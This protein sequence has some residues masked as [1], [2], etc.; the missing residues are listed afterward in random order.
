MYIYIYIHK[1]YN[2]INYIT[3]IISLGLPRAAVHD[4]V[5]VVAHALGELPDPPGII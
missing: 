5:D 3:I 1:L 4:E 2:Y